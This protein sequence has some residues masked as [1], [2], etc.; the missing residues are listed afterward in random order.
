MGIKNGNWSGGANPENKKA[1][2]LYLQTVVLCR[3]L[4]ERN[5]KSDREGDHYNRILS[6]M[7]EVNRLVKDQRKQVFAG[8]RGN[9][10]NSVRGS[11]KK[12]CRRELNTVS[13][14]RSQ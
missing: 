10:P 14:Q 6:C 5:I 11:K 3:L 7:Q 12:K 4:E 13:V 9:R 8:M 2:G 1:N